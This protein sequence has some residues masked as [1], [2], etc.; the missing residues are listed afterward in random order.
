MADYGFLDI[1][2]ESDFIWH[3]IDVG[4][5]VM[6]EA[7]IYDGT[8]L[9]LM[10]G[11]AY[12]VLAK[13]REMPGNSMLVVESCVTGELINLHP[14]LICHYQNAQAPVSYS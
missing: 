5:H 6:T 2:V 9:Q 3:E 1:L 12:L 10:R 14:A 7:D 11:Q 13:I 8:G 4:D